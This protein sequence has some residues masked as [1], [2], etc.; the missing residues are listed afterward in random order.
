MLPYG[1]HNPPQSIG[2]LLIT[3]H[4]Q[5]QNLVISLYPT[6]YIDSKLPCHPHSPL[7]PRKHRLHHIVDHVDAHLD[8]L[9]H[10]SHQMHHGASISSTIEFGS[11]R[12]HRQTQVN[13]PVV[14]ITVLQSQDHYSTTY[15]FRSAR[16]QS[17]N[18]ISGW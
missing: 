7:S 15:T 16:E 6:F 4:T 14:W 9:H 5:G 18:Q 17:L 8:P 11:L 10:Y 3:T 2:P 1:A 12:F 13:I